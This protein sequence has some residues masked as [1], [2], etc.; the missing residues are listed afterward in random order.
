MDD[1]DRLEVERECH[2]ARFADDSDG[3]PADRFYAV[4]QA[5][6]RWYRAEIERATAGAKGLDYGCGGGGVRP[7]PAPRKGYDVVAIDISPVAID[8]AREQAEREGVAERI[9]FRVMNAE[10]IDL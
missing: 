5:S 6:D 8:H 7:L 10:E 1:G 9:H 3:R 4:N 2:D